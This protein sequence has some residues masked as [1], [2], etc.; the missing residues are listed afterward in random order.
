MGIVKH[1][2]SLYAV[3]RVLSRRR[4]MASF[5]LNTAFKPSGDQEQ[6]IAKLLKSLEAGNKH[7]ALLGVTGSGKTFT[8]ANLIARMNRPT[9]VISHNKTL[10]AQLHSELKSF[11]P[12]NAVD[13]YVSY[14]DYYQPEAYIASTDTYIEKD[15]AIND[16]LDRLSLNAMNSL[17]TRR[18]VI[19]VASVSCIYGLSTPEDYRNLTLA[20]CEGDI[21][22]RDVFLKNLVERLFERQ[23]FDFVRGSFRVRGEIV[24][25]YPAYSEGEAIRVEFFGDEIERISLIDAMSG[26]VRERLRNYTFFP[27]KQYVAAP[28]KRAVA[29][30]AIRDELAERV[31]WF[32]KQ[33]RLLEAQRLKMR[34]EYDLE[35]ISELGF[36]K[37]IENYSR[38]LSGRL[39]GSAPSTLL[40]FFPKDSLT[41]IDESHAAVPQI[42]GMYEGDRSRKN[43]LVEHGFRLPS[44]LD[45]RPLKF[46]EFMERQ[47]QIVY[48]SATPG[49]FELIN[50]RVD[51]K[52]FIPVRRAG[53]GADKVPEDFK[54]I[55]FHSPKD[56]RVSPSP[57]SEPIEK[58][59]PT[60]R[61]TPL[62]VEQIIRPTGL[63][64]PIITIRPLK[65]QIDETIA[66]CNERVAKHERVLVT[67]LTKR[68]AEDLTEYLKGVGLR[69]SYIHA[70]VDAIQRV[71]ILRALRAQKIDVLVGINLLREGLDLPEVS[72][73]C[74][75]D[76]DKEGFLRNETSLVQTAGRA[77]RHVHGECVLFADVMTDSIQRLIELTNYRRSIQQQY[78]EKHGITP[79]TVS[80]SEQGRLRLYDDEDE[81]VSRMAESDADEGLPERI[82]RLEVEMKEAS[83]H[84]EFERAAMIRD[85]IKALK[86]G[87]S[88]Y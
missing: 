44:A 72:L 48:A 52:T 20:I 21:M 59:D 78:N 1:C 39:P 40:D 73:V 47:N 53:R 69:V 33:G 18:D 9:L 26:R 22:D 19:V 10:A 32:E 28:E 70:D 8:M 43:I 77:A 88:L 57:S 13:Y 74:I 82:A 85:E 56:I 4:L 67:T 83:S 24:E 42:G 58:F 11:F 66:L 6:A 86:E 36:C 76:A 29:L 12:N 68:T 79:M 2:P 80:R 7:Q 61:R 55:V 75:L 45:N 16:E 84:L 50:C 63:L 5:E 51:N 27:A 71:E 17:L 41:L 64:E 81:N 25:V 46:H 37:G 65:N 62:I 30:R 38:H 34:T 87:K 31:A 23:D 14:F 15:S 54:G 3:N 60:K 35:L 49:P